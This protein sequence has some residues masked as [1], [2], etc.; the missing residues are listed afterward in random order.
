MTVLL[1]LAIVVVAVVV[2]VVVVGY[3][4]YREK[5][6]VRQHSD[7]FCSFKIKYYNC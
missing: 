4:S 5:H 6:N 2:V 3:Y 7:K 1:L